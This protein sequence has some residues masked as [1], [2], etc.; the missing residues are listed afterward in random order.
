MKRNR[1][2][3]IFVST[4][5]G[6]LA[7]AGVSCT[8]P[9]GGTAGGPSSEMASGGG[10]LSL[11]SSAFVENGVIPV[12]YSGDGDNVS[13][14]LSW[15]G[16]PAGTQS[17][18]VT[19]VDPDVPW[20]QDVPGYGTMPDPGTQPGDLF[21]HWMAANIPADVTAL[22]D[23]ASPGNMPPGTVEPQSS[24]A[25][26]AMPANQYGGPAPPPQLKAHEYVFTLYAM[27]VASLPGI[28]AE[29]DYAALTQAMAGHVLATAELEGY[30]GH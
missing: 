5:V 13:P 11:T 10:T 30:F 29:S 9:A 14:P 23:G 12:R 21:I 25:L 2:A 20:G 8:A 3:R 15:T 17:F 24:F 26:F 19:L 22:A 6:A 18:V 1:I 16:A 7:V 28:T 27:D 4:A